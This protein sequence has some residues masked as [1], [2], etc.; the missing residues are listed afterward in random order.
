MEHN[1]ELRIIT[2]NTVQRIVRFMVETGTEEIIGKLLFE[3][4]VPEISWGEL[5]QKADLSAEELKKLQE[6][7]GEARYAALHL[8]RERQEQIISQD[9]LTLKDLYK[10]LMYLMADEVKWNKTLEIVAYLY[11]SEPDII[12]EMPIKEIW[13]LIQN[14]LKDAGFTEA[15]S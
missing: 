4:D 10:E 14:A 9:M 7:Y 15:L 12:G 8:E 5:R 11:Q 3:S 13:E 2:A 1:L 6:L